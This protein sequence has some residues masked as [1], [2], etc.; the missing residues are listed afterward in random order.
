MTGINRENNE[1]MQVEKVE[2]Y[3]RDNIFDEF[4]QLVKEVSE[5]SKINDALNAK[6]IKED[7]SLKFSFE[8]LKK[9]YNADIVYLMNK[10]GD[11][12]I[13]TEYDNGKSLKGNNYRFREYFKRALKGNP[14][15]F[16]ATGVTTGERG[17]YFS[18][19]IM[20]EGNVNGVFV[21]KLG[22]HEIERF[23]KDQNCYC[24]I[25]AE[26][27]VVFI[28]SKKDLLYT[29]T[30][31]DIESIKKELI[32]TRQFPSEKIKSPDYF[33][34]TK[35]KV[36]KTSYNYKKYS[37]LNSQWKIYY[38]NDEKIYRLMSKQ[39]KVLLIGNLLIAVLVI[40]I[41]LL[42]E[43]IKKRFHAENEVIKNEK[44]LRTVFDSAIE[45]FCETTEVGIIQ[46]INGYFEVLLG[47]EKEELIGKNIIDFV[48]EDSVENFKKLMG[49]DQRACNNSNEIRL[50]RKNN[51]YIICLVCI[52]K[53]LDENSN[54]ITSFI[55]FTD[56]TTRKLSIE[57]KNKLNEEL[58]N[59]VKERTRKLEES[60]AELK[61]TQI[62]LQESLKKIQKDEEG[63]KKLQ[64]KLLPPDVVEIGEYELSHFLMPSMYL[65]G[66]FVDYFQI[67][68]RY[69][70]FYLADV[71]GHG[72]SS[73]FVTIM[74]K[75][76]IDNLYKNK[77][78]DIFLS[79][80]KIMED[81][82]K[83]FLMDSIGKYLTILLGIIDK[84][85]NKILYSNAGQ[86]PDPIFCTEKK[87]EFLTKNSPPIGLFDFSKYDE[88][89]IDCNEDFFFIVFS[90][91]ILEI[92]PGDSMETKQN[93]LKNLVGEEGFDINTLIMESGLEN[94]THLPDDVT[95]LFIN[96]RSEDE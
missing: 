61:N 26:N 47:Y 44:K 49:I 86:F 7:C 96:K 90:D 83:E 39:K 2:F 54:Q 88:Y 92:A 53:I 64:D 12:I 41:L 67:D 31:E 91:G 8:V 27:D 29:Y 72:V 14:V 16:S 70:C 77:N 15:I 21:L 78:K 22:V 89:E 84:K 5:F 59:K 23:L 69:I 46:N 34:E 20:V 48:K 73:A 55:V 38:L 85:E 9:T 66:D 56:I 45:G 50:K 87:C 42:I 13:S 4:K 3:L 58:E 62:T 36:G 6:E 32:T 68:D 17:I 43:N 11:V 24:F 25:T 63:G 74:L 82:N 28:S 33:D 94:T 57:E 37:I 93:W 19:P 52:T 1:N 71:S 51:V 79:P 81:L 80:K 65:S 18:A 76:Y 95:F 10:N 75:S 60:N 30:G 40:F 35:I